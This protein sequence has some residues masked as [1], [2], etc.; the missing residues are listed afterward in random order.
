MRFPLAVLSVLLVLAIPAFASD[1]DR[2]IEETATPCSLAGAW[3]GGS[4]PTFPYA[5]TMNPINGN[6]LTTYAEIAAVGST[7]G[8][9]ELYPWHG[10]AQRTAAGT[11]EWWGYCFA[12][13]QPELA[14][15]L[16]VDPTLPEFDIVHA[17]IEF[18]DCNTIT[19]TI[20]VFGW[21]YN[22]KFDRTPFVDPVDFSALGEG[23]TLVE[24]YHRLPMPAIAP[25][26]ATPRFDPIPL[27][28]SNTGRRPLRKR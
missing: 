3:Y 4:D 5:W 16:G 1:A 24:T 25:L 23:E 14:E 28:D 12:L 8:Y 10:V 7:F 9:A 21:Y 6:S 2:P 26:H 18:V 15:E 13:L 19:S 20:D 17:V 22:F 11:W 27:S